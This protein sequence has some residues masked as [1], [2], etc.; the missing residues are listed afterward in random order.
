[1]KVVFH[2]Q[3][4]EGLRARLAA[5]AALGLE[6]EVCPEADEARFASLMRDAEALWHWLKPVTPA[7]IA[8]APRL[9]LIQKLGV[10]VNTIDLDAAKSRGVA[11]CNMPGANSRAV[12][13]LALAL[14]LAVLR[15]L[16][17]YDRE[18]RAGRGWQV[19]PATFDRLGEIGGRTVGLIG[20]GSIPALV[21]PALAALGARPIY[22]SRTRREDFPAAYRALDEL[23]A[24]S[25]IVSLHVPIARETERLIDAKAIA[26]MKPG[27]ILINTAR[28][29]LVDQAA[30]VAAL[31]SGRLA[32]AGLD[33]FA[34]EPIAPDDPLLALPNVALTPHVGGLTAETLARSVAI[35]AENCRRL[36]A[37]EA[38]LHRVV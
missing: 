30:L 32:G 7:V 37:G 16:A 34:A 35:A 4:G 31:K 28:G 18:T 2:Y 9:R 20:A 36:A 11:V 23:L 1:M 22:W 19:D 13:E 3:A 12:A 21:A 17:A 27:A 10:G 5:L 8:A 26:R 6:V 33:V 38:L 15:R 14:M 29:A 24:E 25:D